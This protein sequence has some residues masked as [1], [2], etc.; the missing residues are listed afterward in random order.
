MS[1]AW[2]TAGF[3]KG[4]VKLNTP[5]SHHRNLDE[6][7]RSALQHLPEQLV[8]DSW[9]PCIEAD[10]WERIRVSLSLNEARV[11]RPQN[12]DKMRQSSGDTDF[13]GRGWYDHHL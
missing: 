9:N 13:I 12:S 2:E 6:T 10:F 7:Q 3:N 11:Q 1:G 4:Q 5:R 8:Q